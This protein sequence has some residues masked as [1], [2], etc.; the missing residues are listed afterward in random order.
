M[1]SKNIYEI[2][3]VQSYNDWFKQ[4]RYPR[5]DVVVLDQILYHSNKETGEYIKLAVENEAYADLICFIVIKR[6]MDVLCVS[7]DD[8]VW[9]YDQYGKETRLTNHQ[10][11][12]FVEVLKDDE[13]VLGFVT[14]VKN[15]MYTVIT[16]SNMKSSLL[17]DA[18]YIFKPHF[19][20]PVRTERRLKKAIETFKNKNNKQDIEQ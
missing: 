1:G 15:G 14:D 9:V 20:I 4:R 12:D 16:S 3:V 17:V 2:K 8:S 19:K 10:V 6:P 13:I 18:R 5:F 11:G 7:K